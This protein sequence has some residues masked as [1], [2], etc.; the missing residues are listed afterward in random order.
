M[1]IDWASKVPNCETVSFLL[2]L[3]LEL[4]DTINKMV[5]FRPFGLPW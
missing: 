2:R 4:V 5:E 3:C 1:E